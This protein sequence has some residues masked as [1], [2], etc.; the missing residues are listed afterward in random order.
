MKKLYSLFAVA[1][2]GVLSASAFTAKT[3]SPNS[4]AKNFGKTVPFRLDGQQASP[5][6]SERSRVFGKLP[7][8]TAAKPLTRAAEDE[9]IITEAPAGKHLT[10]CGSSLSFYVDYG[11]VNMDEWFGLAYDAVLTDDGDFYLQNPVSS[12]QFGTYI[13]GKVTENGVEFEFPQPVYKLEDD[14][15]DEVV[16]YADVLEYVEVETPDGDYYTTFEPSKNTRTLTFDVDDEGNYIM[17]IDY[18]LG[19]TAFDTWQGFGE[20]NLVLNPFE[21]EVTKVPES[22]V[23]NDSY[24]LADE[25]LGWDHTI[26]NPVSIGFDGNDAYIKGAFQAMPEAVIKASVDPETKN[27]TLASNQLMGRFYNYYI[28]YMNGDGYEYYDDD[29]QSDMI[30]IEFTDEITLVYD[31]E[32]DVYTPATEDD[33]FGVFIFN[34][35]NVADTPCEYYAVDRIYSQGEIT[36]YSPVAPVITDIYSV[37]AQSGGEYSYCVEFMLFGDNDE[38][39]ILNDN[40]IYYNIFV[41][42]ELYPLTAEEFPS[43]EY[44]G[45]KSITDIP[46][47]LSDDDDIFAMGSYHGISFRNKDIQTIGVRALYIDGSIRA[48]S[49]IVTVDTDGNTVAVDEIGDAQVVATEYYDLSGCRVV[50][51]AAGS[52]SVCKSVLSNGSVKYSKVVIR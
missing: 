22:V 46:I 33:H 39:Q 31:A 17:D 28:F 45:L 16:I 35:G 27:L 9:D 32:N 25:I 26:L 15:G 50:S 8:Q 36:N 29:W 12:F 13:K 10:F 43:L 5:L 51:P 23:Y 14:S 41:N 52:I 40:N 7:A 4:F 38:G 37:E 21:A 2:A 30:S 6:K 19:L 49:E 47:A 24:I 1:M 42:G 11:E 34:F 48:E 20:Y 3:G 44:M 18:M